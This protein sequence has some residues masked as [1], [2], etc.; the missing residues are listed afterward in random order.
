MLAQLLAYSPDTV[1]PD[2]AA[3]DTA[4][5]L[6]RV[7][8]GVTMALHGYGKFFQ[9]GRITGTAGGVDSAGQK[10]GKV[11]ALM[12]ASTEVGA[13]LGFALGLLTPL[14]AAG[15]VGLM[16]VAGW[17]VHRHNGFFIVKS[18]WEYNLIL[19]VGAVAVAMLGPGAFSLDHVLGLDKTLSGWLGLALSA[20]LGIL[21]G[22]G[23]LVAVYRPP[24]P[25]AS[26]TP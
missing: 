18:G 22:V 25:E 12:A 9:G 26:D 17:T 19:A 10:P 11:M 1:R 6:L 20:G 5:L 15:L 2:A 3:I 8:F 16:I 24:A 13:G 14:M 23:L 7:T 21:G 4:L